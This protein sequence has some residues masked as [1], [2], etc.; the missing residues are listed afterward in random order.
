[1]DS[2]DIKEEPSIPKDNKYLE[3][4]YEMQKQLLDSY[5]S[6]E[7]LPKYPLNINTK[8]NQ[9]ILKDFTSRVIEELAEAYESLLLVE[10]LTITK[11]KIEET[12]NLINTNTDVEII[13]PTKILQFSK[14]CYEKADYINSL[15]EQ[16]DIKAGL[17]ISNNLHA[18]LLADWANKFA[19]IQINNNINEY[20]AQNPVTIEYSETN[21]TNKS[22][23]ATIKTNQIV[24]NTYLIKTEALHL[25]TQ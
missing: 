14:D 9:L 22:V 2:R 4:I 6:I 23:K 10:E 15:E 17:I 12:E 1:M 25:N 20:I 7:G 19:S 8:T 21:I 3:S 18:Q 24:K 13:Y 16:N 5:I 11:Q